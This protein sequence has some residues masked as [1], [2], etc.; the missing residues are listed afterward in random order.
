M[1]LALLKRFKPTHIHR[2]CKDDSDVVIFYFTGGYSRKC[3]RDSLILIT[4]QQQMKRNK[5]RKKKS[6]SSSSSGG[7][8]EPVRLGRN[9]SQRRRVRSSSWVVVVLLLEGKKSRDV[10]GEGIRRKEVGIE[11]RK[12]E[13]SVAFASQRNDG[14]RRVWYQEE[15]HFID[16]FP[17]S[18]YYKSGERVTLFLLL[19]C[20]VET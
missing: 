3:L 6:S 15:R 9:N 18:P 1:V 10:D 8:S 2:K 16:S 14:K 4:K 11:E 17:P 13:A 7:T 19:I 12:G 20:A 5:S